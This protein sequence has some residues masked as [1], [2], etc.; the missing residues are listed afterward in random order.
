MTA[1]WTENTLPIILSGYPLENIF[2]SDEFGLFYQC[3]PNKILH[4]KGEK[5]SGGKYSKVLLTG[6]A[7]GNAYE[8]RLQMSV[9]G[10]SVKPRCFKDVKTLPW[11][12][13]AEHKSWMPGELFRDWV[14]ELDRKFAVSKRK[15]ALIIDNYMAHPHVENLKWVEFIFLP[16]NTTSHTQAMDHII[17]WALLL[18]VRKLVLALEKK[19]PIMDSLIFPNTVL[20]K[21]QNFTEKFCWTGAKFYLIILLHH[22]LYYLNICGLINIS[23]LKIIVYI[24]LIFQ[25]MVSILSVTWWT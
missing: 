25:I 19:E 6:L 12:D 14:H 9:I 16:P 2:N 4:L 24:F 13:R 1:P 22:P 3:L 23:K 8:E 15:I 17:I 7:A 20:E 18:A 21:C 11:R 10:K 5:C